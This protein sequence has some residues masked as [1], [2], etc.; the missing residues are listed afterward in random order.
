MDFEIFPDARTDERGL[1]SRCLRISFDEP[2]IQISCKVHHIC[3]AQCTGD[4]HLCIR[5][6]CHIRFCSCTLL[7][8]YRPLKQWVVVSISGREQESHHH[9]K[10]SNCT[11]PYFLALR[12]LASNI[13][14]KYW[15][16]YI[17]HIIFMPT[18]SVPI[19][20]LLIML[21]NTVE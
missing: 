21:R 4:L 14:A 13:L 3:S 16:N 5:I 2:K 20:Q 11:L 17:Y 10:A 18:S 1:N 19:L 15:F 12:S 9:L 6:Y 7:V 8:L